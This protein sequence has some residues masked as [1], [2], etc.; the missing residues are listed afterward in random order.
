MKASTRVAGLARDWHRR[1]EALSIRTQITWWATAVTV[2]VACCIY[3]LLLVL[4]RR[5]EEFDLRQN[6]A[7]A[8]SR[9]FVR[10]GV[11][12]IDP[13]QAG[14]ELIQV[15]DVRG[16][17]VAWTD[18]M[19]GYPPVDFPAPAFGQG[20]REG[21]SCEV[22]APGGPCYIVV[23]LRFRSGENQRIVY[24]LHDAPRLFWSTPFVAT[25][26]AFCIPLL[27]GLVGFAMWRTT[28]RL[29]RPVDAIRAELD[30]ITAT[31]LQRRVP[32]PQGRDEIWRLARSVN[33]TLDRLE[34]A[35]NRISGFVS[36][37][38]HELRSP[39]TGLRMEVEL[40]LAEPEETDQ[41]QTLRT[42]LA[43]SERLHDVL[44]DLLALARLESTPLEAKD[45]TDLGELA[46][47]EIFRRPRRADFTL[48]AT[49]PVP[50]RGNALELCRLLT[51]L[52]DNADRHATEDVT[53]KV[54]ADEPGTAVLEVI[55]DGPG[56]AP[57]DRERIFE[58]FTRLADGRRRDPGGTGLGLPIARDIAIAHGGTLEVTDRADGLSGARFVLR[59]P[60]ARPR[61]SAPGPSA[62]GSPPSG[63]S[64][65]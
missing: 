23:A 21:R 65:S 27:G 19:A 50:V 20:R 43:I 13:D 11:G 45:E 22:R 59:L 10:T 18:A 61:V 3:V 9:T 28:G 34:R 51:N 62:P 63:S 31:D 53:V 39:L 38:S 55:D 49:E 32:E 26:L 36:D 46:E 30:E 14:T 29:I 56:V 58:R 5:E 16:R 24:A 1:F 52:L 17:V 4:L 48:V 7:N 64:S 2:L 35:V 57:K 12:R 47:Q 60:I 25:V 54:A 41:R 6:L 40:A 37:V 42:V 8:A 33:A 44:D 15:V